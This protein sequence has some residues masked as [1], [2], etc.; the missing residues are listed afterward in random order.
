MHSNLCGPIRIT[1]IGS[2]RY[3]VVFIDDFS[4]K[5]WLYAYNDF[6]RKEC[7][8]EYKDFNTLVKTQLEHK[9]K[10]FW[11]DNGKGFI[12]KA[13]HCI[14]EDHDIDYQIFIPYIPQ[15]NGVSEHMNHT[16]MDMAKNMF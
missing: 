6:S 1:S 3:F 2:A 9:V 16:I 15:Q 8:E 11:L 4:R 7:Y 14:L 5:V 13:F 12:S 10:V